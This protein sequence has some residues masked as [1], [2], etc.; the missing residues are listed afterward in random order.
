M[1]AGASDLIFHAALLGSEYKNAVPSVQGSR[2]AR[3]ALLTGRE[4]V[5]GTLHALSRVASAPEVADAPSLIGEALTGALD[6][7]RFLLRLQAAIL[8]ATEDS[9]VVRLAESL[10]TSATSSPYMHTGAN[11]YLDAFEARTDRTLAFRARAR[12]TRDLLIKASGLFGLAVGPID[13]GQVRRSITFPPELKQAAVGVLS[14]FS[15]VLDQKYPG[16]DVGVA[17][18]QDGAKVTMVVTTPEGE[19]DRIDSELKQYGLVMAGQLSPAEYL[20]DPLH[21]V[22]LEHKLELASLELRHTRDLLASERER[23]GE[24]IASLED[25][26]GF[27]KDALDSERQQAQV[28]VAALETVATTAI[29]AAR[30]TLTQAAELISRRNDSTLDDEALELLSQAAIEDPSIVDRLNELL[31]QGAVQGAA[32]NFLFSWIQALLNMAR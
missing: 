29:P 5:A 18:R 7:L 31:I 27:L 25:Q 15:V 13:Q 4:L 28:L 32:G 6:Q 1:P 22:R 23:H 2:S 14:Y 26:V 12:A 19:E 3:V 9:E 17:I 21:I 24:R 8:P 20:N 11:R 30:D 16:M 10:V